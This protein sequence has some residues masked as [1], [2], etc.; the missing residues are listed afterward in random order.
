MANENKLAIFIDYDNIEMSVE[1]LLGKGVEVDWARLLQTA[2]S[3]GRVIVRRAYADWAQTHERK[4]RDLLGIG[5]ELIYVNSRRGKNAA[6]IRIVIDTLELLLGEKCEFTHVMLVSGDGDFTDLVH[7]LRAQGKTVIGMG[8]TG[9]SAEYLVN[10]C[11]KFMYYDKLSGIS[12]AKKMIQGPPASRVNGG[13]GKSNGAVPNQNRPAPIVNALATT[14]EGKLE[15]YQ[16]ILSDHKIRITPT[17][18][19]PAIIFKLYELKKINPDLTFKQL[20]DE[21]QTYYAT[22]NS[23]IESTY[24]NDIAHQLFHTFCFD[25]DD[26]S[27]E[28]IL[29]RKMCFAPE[30]KKAPDLLDQ[31]DRKI[32]QLLVSAFGSPDK[33]DAEVAAKL[34]YGSVRTPRMVEHVQGL[35]NAEVVAS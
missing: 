27:S 7:R 15:Q 21:A 35:I 8:V 25:F 23:M 9:K 13:A 6:D 20:K 28:R 22:N 19:R 29:D 4:Q 24:V 26:D 10:A 14:P 34:L 11:D 3:M 2:S 12:K 17:E 31:C 32:M 16:S 30:I 18:K 33:V 5:V 1:E